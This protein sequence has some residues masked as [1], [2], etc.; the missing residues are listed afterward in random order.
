MLLYIGATDVLPLALPHHQHSI[1]THSETGTA[2]K[3]VPPPKL[4]SADKQEIAEEGRP[5]EVEMKASSDREHEHGHG[6][7]HG[8]GHNALSYPERD[9]AQLA[10]ACAHAA[11]D[12]ASLSRLALRALLVPAGMGLV[13][14]STLWHVH[15]DA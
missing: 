6:H 7:G 11:P 14:L 12:D 8:H 3:E 2:A 1:H 5:A 4:A 15:C 9:A 13:A 10:E